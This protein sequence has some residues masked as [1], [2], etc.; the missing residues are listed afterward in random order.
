LCI[1]RNLYVG[2]TT[3]LGELGLDELGWAN[4][5]WANLD[6]AKSSCIHTNRQYNKKIHHS[7]IYKLLH[8][9][10]WLRRIKYFSPVSSLSLEARGLKFCI[11]TSMCAAERSLEENSNIS[12]P[13]QKFKILVGSFFCIKVKSLYA[14]FQPPSFQSEGV[15]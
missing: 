3:T 5:D 4:L 11:Q 13:R 10:T 1:G 8:L 6:W 7:K 15:V 12:A 14:K 9:L 2:R